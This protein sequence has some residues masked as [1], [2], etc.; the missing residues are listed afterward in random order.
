MT[1]FIPA[2]DL[3][4]KYS[5]KGRFYVLS[6]DN[7]TTKCRS[8]L[9]I[10]STTTSN[11]RSLLVVML[12]PG[13]SRPFYN[14]YIETEISTMHIDDLEH[15]P[16]ID[17]KPAPTQYQI[18]RVMNELKFSFANIINLLDIRETKSGHLF[19]KV[20]NGNIATEASIFS[21]TRQT[22]LRNYFTS[23]TIVI[24]AWGNTR[25]IFDYEKKALEKISSLTD[26]VF[27]VRGN[28]N[29]IC[30][31]SPQNQNLKIKWLDNI[32]E[33]LKNSKT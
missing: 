1:E 22:E 2:A 27:T 5:V 10:S 4:K 32:F 24:L 19:D 29:R 31:P 14:E 28:D 15:I 20:K 16:L 7:S 12:N 6:S 11:K 8:L 3:K 21:E 33:Q 9:T 30:H 17:V 25:A 26:K 13:S 23:D 18:M